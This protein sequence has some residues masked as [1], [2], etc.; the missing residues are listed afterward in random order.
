MAEDVKEEPKKETHRTKFLILAII[1]ML[2]FITLW[3]VLY[4]HIVYDFS[5]LENILIAIAFVVFYSLLFV[6]KHVQNL[7]NKALNW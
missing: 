7:I 6:K 5:M 1:S 2:Q 3:F 4:N